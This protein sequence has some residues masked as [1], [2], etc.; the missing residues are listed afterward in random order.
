M[1]QGGSWLQATEQEIHATSSHIVQAS[2]SQS[3]RTHSIPKLRRITGNIE[4]CKLHDALMMI[5]MP[6]KFIHSI[7]HSIIHSFTH[8]FT[9]SLIH[10]LIHS[11]THSFTPSLI[12][13][14]IRMTWNNS[15]LMFYFYHQDQNLPTAD[16]FSDY[17]HLHTHQQQ[18]IQHKQH[19]PQ[20]QQQYQ[21]QQQHDSG[22]FSYESMAR[23]QLHSNRSLR[24][25]ASFDSQ[26]QGFNPQFFPRRQGNTSHDKRFPST[27]SSCNRYA[28][29]DY[30]TRANSFDILHYAGALNDDFDMDCLEASENRTRGFSAVVQLPKKPCLDTPTS[31]FKLYRMKMF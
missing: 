23:G 24:D 18:L 20:L 2:G 31:P 17:A 3:N 15:N 11:F 27:E 25:P 16:I 1:V 19:I 9:H 29:H 10:S 14:P 4:V 5:I 7:I 22:T 8:S 26:Y 21:Q 13:P 28:D 30:A 12:Q 6:C